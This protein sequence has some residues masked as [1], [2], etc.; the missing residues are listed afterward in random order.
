VSF[1]KGRTCGSS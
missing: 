1:V